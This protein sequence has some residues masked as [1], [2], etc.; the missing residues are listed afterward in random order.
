[1]QW[2]RSEFDAG[3]G[4][5]AN[6]DPDPDADPGA[7]SNTDPHSDSDTHINTDAHTDPNTYAYACACACAYDIK[8]GSQCW[9]DFRCIY[10]FDARPFRRRDTQRRR[11]SRGR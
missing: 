5:D 2:K 3:A 1:M 11:H 10:G 6:S 7:H 9:R 8:R 4:A